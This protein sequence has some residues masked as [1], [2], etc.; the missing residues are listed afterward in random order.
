MSMSPVRLAL[1]VLAAALAAGTFLPSALATGASLRVR[2]TAASAGSVVVFTGSVGEGCS[3]GDRVTLISRLF[4]GH[5][6]GGEGAITARVGTHDHF[7]RSFRV[8]AGTAHKT[9]IVT[10]RCGGGN[11]GVSATLRVH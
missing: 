10:A 2:P 6:F 11:L 8:R 1:L 9:F 5:A 7:T 4:P 3:H